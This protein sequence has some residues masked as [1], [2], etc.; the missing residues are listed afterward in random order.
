MNLGAIEAGGTKF[1]YAVGDEQGKII[2]R[3]SIPT[4]TPKETMNN[5][6]DFFRGYSISGIGL[7]S[8]GPVDLH[9]ESPLYGHITMTPKVAWRNYD[10]LGEL[11]KHFPIP[12]GFDT[13][14][15]AAAY[16]EKIWGAAKDV[17]SCIYMTVGTG[18]GVGAIVGGKL[19]HG[20]IHPEMG[21]ILVR[22]HPL[23]QYEGK[24]PY[25]KD[26]LEGLASGPA[27]SERW[28][29]AGLELHN[30]AEVWEMEA[31]YLAQALV[32]YLLIL[33]PKKIILGGGVMMQEQLFPLIQNKVKE[34]INGYI[35]HSAIL[36][37][38]EE[39]IVPASLGQNAGISGALALAIKAI[40]TDLKALKNF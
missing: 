21:H 38:I 35:H 14:V 3:V 25:H 18:I 15:N 23:D 36:L 8:F 34:L 24:C 27:I 16:G 37:D 20:L 17:D 2:E 4:T 39:Y 10:V 5:V 33:S 30:R 7:G 29:K 12:I 26:C 13:D 40:N 9:V 19:L 1:V 28:G 31:F 22:R 32:N 6:I 11:K